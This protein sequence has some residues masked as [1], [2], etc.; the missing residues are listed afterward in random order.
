MDSLPA[1]KELTQRISE[2][3]K[4]TQEMKKLGL[5][6]PSPSKKEKYDS[7]DA[8]AQLMGGSGLGISKEIDANS[9]TLKSPG[10]TV[11]DR[12]RP[13]EGEGYGNS[14]RPKSRRGY[15]G[16][17]GS[18]V[19]PSF[20]FRPTSRSTATQNEV[21]LDDEEA[22]IKATRKSMDDLNAKLDLNGIDV[23]GGCGNESIEKSVV[24][25]EQLQD[26]MGNI[27]QM[28]AQLGITPT[29]PQ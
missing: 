14:D 19:R 22:L 9:M 16:P 4:L 8:D 6:P 3:E 18:R 26:A 28:M 17:N 29:T 2:L 5:A 27:E 11:R 1:E 20:G 10:G 25:L 15:E 7:L 21:D 13:V 24:K 12:F 23:S